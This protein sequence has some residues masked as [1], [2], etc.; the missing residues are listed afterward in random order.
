MG[1]GSQSELA[2][3]LSDAGRASKFLTQPSPTDV[4][5]L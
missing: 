3:E 5:V 1:K 4:A 2:Y